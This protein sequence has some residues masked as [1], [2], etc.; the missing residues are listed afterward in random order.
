MK[1]KAGMI[2]K[3]LKGSRNY[4][5]VLPVTKRQWKAGVNCEKPGLHLFSGYWYTR[6]V[7]GLVKGE[8]GSNWN[9][10]NT[11]CYGKINP[12]NQKLKVVGYARTSYLVR[13]KMV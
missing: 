13:K 9:Y 4:W 10:K 11:W 7:V 8:L 2:V 12:C 3:T 5:I 6:Q 1:L